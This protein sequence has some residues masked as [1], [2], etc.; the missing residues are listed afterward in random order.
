MKT[1]SLRDMYFSEIK[2]VIGD[3][4]KPVYHIEETIG[5]HG[6]IQEFNTYKEAEEYLSYLKE[7]NTK[8]Y[9]TLY[10]GK[11]LED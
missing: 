5:G 4:E 7:L 6:I 3:N 8:G 11:E 2:K 9:A 10:K 1:Y